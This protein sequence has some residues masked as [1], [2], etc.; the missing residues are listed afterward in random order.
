MGVFRVFGPVFH[1][2]LPVSYILLPGPV[3]HMLLPGPISH[4]ILLG[5]GFNNNNKS[6]KKSQLAVHFRRG[7][8][9][10]CFVFSTVTCLS[11]IVISQFYTILGKIM[12]EYL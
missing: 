2:L 5:Q 8:L 11:G 3:C 9:Y 6:I 4:I 12:V 1:R 10:F 7:S